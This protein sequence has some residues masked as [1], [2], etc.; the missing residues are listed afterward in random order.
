MSALRSPKRKNKPIDRRND[1]RAMAK[2]WEKFFEEKE[3]E[4]GKRLVDKS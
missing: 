2:A 1:P 3:K 4:D